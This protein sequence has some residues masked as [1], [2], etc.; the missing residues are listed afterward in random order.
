MCKGALGREDG[1]RG[2]RDDQ[3]EVEMEDILPQP[4]A[5]AIPQA[6]DQQR[7]QKLHNQ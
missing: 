4:Y 7:H 1:Q 2:N 5:V 6:D 3:A